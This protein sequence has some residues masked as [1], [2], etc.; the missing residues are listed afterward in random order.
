MIENVKC[1]GLASPSQPWCQTPGVSGQHCGLGNKGLNVQLEMWNEHPHCR[2][3]PWPSVLARSRRKVGTTGLWASSAMPR[4]LDHLT[5]PRRKA[6]RRA[7]CGESGQQENVNGALAF[8]S[9]A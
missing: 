5:S 3:N 4:E 1:A 2:V 6:G 9:T 8:V 7:A